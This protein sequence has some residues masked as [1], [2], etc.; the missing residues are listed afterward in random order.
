MSKLNWVAA[1]CGV[2]LV[3]ACVLAF[4]FIGPSGWARGYPAYS[5]GIGTWT[6][7]DFWFPFMVM[8]GLCMLVFCA[9]F[10]GGRVRPMHSFGRW[11]GGS[12]IP[13][14]DESPLNVLENRYSRGEISREQ[15]EEMKRE[16]GL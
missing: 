9:L 12:W 1:V 10:M 5:W 16:L 11:Q 4:S 3:L 8:M 7:P 13:P 6:F 2:M 14:R 15:F